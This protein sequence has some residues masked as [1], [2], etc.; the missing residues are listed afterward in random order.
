MS[1]I[2]YIFPTRTRPGNFQQRLIEI[3]TLSESDNYEIIVVADEDDM[4]MNNRLIRGI[5]SEAKNCK[6]FYGESK[7]KI[8]ACNRCINEISEGTEIVVL[9]SDDMKLLKKG[10]DQDIREGF[11]D[12]FR[13]LLHFP[14]GIQDSA[15][16]TFPVMSIGY[17][18][19]F[20]FFYHPDYISVYSDKEMT[21]V[22]ILLGQYKY[23][24]KTI[25]QH[26]HYRA[27]TCGMDALMAHNDS[28]QMYRKDLMTYN[29]RKQINFEV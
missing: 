18:K 26:L 3:E 25:I 2:T 17:L 22:A 9:I 28:A 10:F 5:V 7:S 13:G 20:G 16:C 11:A 4:S 29:R 1:K 12:F 21:E 6:I 15:M 27:G 14:D 23:I 8:H 19:R 24:N